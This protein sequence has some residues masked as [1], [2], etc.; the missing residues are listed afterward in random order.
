MIVLLN[1]LSLLIK[2]L[3]LHLMGVSDI[4]ELLLEFKALSLT[5]FQSMSQVIILIVALPKFLV[6]GHN[7]RIGHVV[8]AVE[9]FM[10]ICSVIQLVLE[11]VDIVLQLQDLQFLSMALL[12]DLSQLF[13]K[14][15]DFLFRLLDCFVLLNDL[16]FGILQALLLRCQL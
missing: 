12:R 9:D 2:C 14:F 8:I 13:L 16:I 10:L 3:N 5:A 15:G 11:I 4:L 6:E 7:L 1:P